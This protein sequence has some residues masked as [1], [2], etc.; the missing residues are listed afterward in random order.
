M[1]DETE[2]VGGVRDERLAQGFEFSVASVYKP[3]LQNRSPRFRLRLSAKSPRPLRSVRWK[4]EG[5]HHPIFCL[6][7]LAGQIVVQIEV[8]PV[9]KGASLSNNW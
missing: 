1:V 7:A 8:R 4:V 6:A 3:R 2:A 5:R 9:V